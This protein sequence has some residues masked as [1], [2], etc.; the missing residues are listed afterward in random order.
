MKLSAEYF[1]LKAEQL[2]ATAKRVQRAQY[3]AFGALAIASGLGFFRLSNPTVRFGMIL[4]AAGS[5]GAAWRQRAAT[6]S[7]GTASSNTAPVAGLDA[8][9]RE[10]QRWRDHAA[11]LWVLAPL[12]PGAVV[13]A[14]PAIASVSRQVA[15]NPALIAR[16]APFCVLLAVW[17]LIF[18]PGRRRRLRNI[19]RELEELDRLL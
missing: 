11:D 1:R 6:A 4:L 3:L 8:Y 9:R 7:S 10:L 5:L 12:V 13:A 18:V 17:F 15:A 16:I 14:L 19:D 2:Q